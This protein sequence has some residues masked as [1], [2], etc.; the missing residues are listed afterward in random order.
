MPAAAPELGGVEFAAVPARER[1]E[2]SINVCYVFLP[3]DIFRVLAR[4]SAFLETL[5]S[6]SARLYNKL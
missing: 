1:E 6:I 4:D 3:R 5:G 2:A